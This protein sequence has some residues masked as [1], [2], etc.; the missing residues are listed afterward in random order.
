MTYRLRYTNQLSSV[1]TMGITEVTIALNSTGLIS[2]SK[3]FRVK[4]DRD[5]DTSISL[6]DKN[7]QCRPQSTFIV[8]LYLSLRN[9]VS[10]L[11]VE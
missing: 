3:H 8:H 7:H 10:V 11:H 1:N 2:T 6:A 5:I 4:E 9:N